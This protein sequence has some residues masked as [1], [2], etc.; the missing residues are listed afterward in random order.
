[1][2]RDGTAYWY[3][4]GKIIKVDH[5]HITDV[6]DNPEKFDLTKDYIKETYK[7]Y[8]ENIG[9]EGKAREEI[10]IEA[11]KKGWIRIRQSFLRQGTVWILQFAD[12]NKQKKD[13]KG[14]VEYLLLDKKEM[15]NYDVL[16]LLSY[17][18]KTDETYDPY[19]GNKPSTFLESLKNVEKVIVEQVNTYN[20]FDY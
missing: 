8:N 9:T 5:L 6:V 12:Y 18:G 7:K 15:K 13:L 3:K 16:R 14:L 11:M 19:Y 2:G 4:H 17:D 20:Y 10:M 1:M